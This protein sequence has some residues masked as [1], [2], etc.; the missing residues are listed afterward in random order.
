MAHNKRASCAPYHAH[1]ITHMHNSKRAK[2]QDTAHRVSERHSTHSRPY[3]RSVACARSLSS[4]II[5]GTETDGHTQCTRHIPHCTYIAPAHSH[6]FTRTHT[7]VYTQENNKVYG[8][9]ANSEKQLGLSKDVWFRHSS[10]QEISWESSSR[11]VAV[12]ASASFTLALTGIILHYN[13]Y[14]ALHTYTH[15]TT[16]TTLHTE[17]RL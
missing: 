7:Y 13:L 11:V 9:G 12:V 14:T 10:P 6:G 1:N 3:H 4:F 8:W 17:P 2:I 15:Y 16:L 5:T